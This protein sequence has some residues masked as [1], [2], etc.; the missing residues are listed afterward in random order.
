[1]APDGVRSLKDTLRQAEASLEDIGE[2]LWNILRGA[3]LPTASADAI[4][5]TAAWAGAQGPE[6]N[7]R[8]L[9]LERMELA[10][11]EL[12]GAGKPPISVD[13]S[14]LAPGAVLPT[15][16]DFW[17]RVG[18]RA[19]A[20]FDPNL[21]SGDPVTENVKGAVESVAG[22]GKMVVDFSPAR[23][24]V[25]FMGWQ[26][27]MDD[28]GTSLVTAVQNP[29]AFAKAALDWDTWATNP[30]RAFGRLI[31]DLVAAITTAGTSSGASA[32]TRAAGALGRAAKNV[33]RPGPSKSPHHLDD[34]LR[35]TSNAEGRAWARDNMP[36]PDLTAKELRALESYGGNGYQRINSGLRAKAVDPGVV[37]SPDVAAEIAAMDRA[38]AKSQLPSDV[39][40]HR[41]VGKGFLEAV[42]VDIES[43]AHME[44]LEGAV[45]TEP[46]YLSTSVGRRAGFDGDVRVLLRVPKGY[47]ALNMYPS[48]SCPPNAR[49]SCRAA[50]PTLCAVCTVKTASG[51]WKRT[52]C[53]RAGPSRPTGTPYRPWTPTPGGRVRTMTDSPNP[54]FYDY[55]TPISVS[56]SD[57]YGFKTTGP[58][59]QAAVHDRDG[60]L[61]GHVWTDDRKAAGFTRIEDPEPDMA[62]AG[63][64]IRLILADAYKA[65]VPASDV[66]DP[67]LYA[68]EF[69]LRR[70]G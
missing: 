31:P 20:T 55:V 36:L 50:H 64:R 9:I 69:E 25:D 47:D 42:G 41:G 4:R 48:P 62:P 67:A 23:A 8:L 28:L 35:H 12:F 1:M 33:I 30:Q 57:S 58:V 56:R 59:R 17:D 44:A 60:R 18:Q 38:L 51:T 53:R 6:I 37:W 45:I 14:L 68:P 49:S 7:R 66:L 5:R 29:A 10:R 43:P 63:V 19:Q 22:L 65:G 54:R 70:D 40:L 27:S 39:V 61:L 21:N 16:G 2:E 13:E 32:T 34:A 15:S 24:V 46:G 52:S 26:R 11:P 3:W